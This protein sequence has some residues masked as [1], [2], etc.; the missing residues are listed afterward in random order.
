VVYDVVNGSRDENDKA[1]G[2]AEQGCE[3]ETAISGIEKDD[4]ND[5]T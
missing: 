3:D 5:D 1:D 2:E 4:R